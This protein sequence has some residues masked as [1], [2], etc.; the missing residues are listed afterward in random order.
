M[1]VDAGGRMRKLGDDPR[2]QRQAG[3]VQVMGDTVMDDRDDAG[4][5][6]QHLVHAARRRIAAI[7]RHH[8]AVQ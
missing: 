3:V 6:Q 1:D 2:Q 7:G 4:I 8:V 5:A